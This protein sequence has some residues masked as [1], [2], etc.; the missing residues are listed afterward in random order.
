L[1]PYLRGCRSLPRPSKRIRALVWLLDQDTINAEDAAHALADVQHIGDRLLLAANHPIRGSRRQAHNLRQALALLGERSVLSLAVTILMIEE[2]GRYQPRCLDTRRFWRR[3][4]ALAITS[5]ALGRR[6][7]IDPAEEALLAGLMQNVGMLVLD[8]VL[9]A[10][11]SG[12]EEVGSLDPNNVESLESDLLSGTNHSQLGAWL[13][14]HWELPER[15]QTIVAGLE[16]GSHTTLGRVDQT[17]LSCVSLS[18]SIASVWLSSGQ[19]GDARAVAAKARKSCGLEPADL[20]AVLNTVATELPEAERVFGV[21]IQEDAVHATESVTQA[22]EHLLLRN[23]TPFERPIDAR[24]P[25]DTAPASAVPFDSLPAWEAVADQ[26]ESEMRQASEHGWPMSVAMIRLELDSD[27]ATRMITLNHATARVLK[28]VRPSDIV[29]RHADGIFGVVLAG[30]ESKGARAAARR[31]SVA[32]TEGTSTANAG[33]SIGLACESSMSEEIDIGE[34]RERANH[35]LD[36]SS[37]VGG[38][39][40]AMGEGAA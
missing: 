36:T 30:T 15:Y 40:L 35:A 29:Y 1:L 6:I 37:R 39:Y 16:P 7:G 38:A 12:F 13:L 2:L 14:E 27:S 3:S 32:F 24:R 9:P 33:L 5:W 8:Q 26:V 21:A 34:L 11:Y 22:K 28:T 25:G 20:A 19:G 31:L 4:M 23:L 17:L 18:T 10:F